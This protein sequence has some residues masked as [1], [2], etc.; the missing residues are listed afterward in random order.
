MKKQSYTLVEF[1]IFEQIYTFFFFIR[2]ENSLSEWPAPA[3]FFG[4]EDGRSLKYRRKRG[5]ILRHSESLT[6]CPMTGRKGVNAV[7]FVHTYR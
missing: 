3:P 4:Q 2:T 1:Q 5:S 6:D 7:Y